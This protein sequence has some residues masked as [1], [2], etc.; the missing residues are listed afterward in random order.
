[1]VLF[2][3]KVPL[4]PNQPR[5]LMMQ[6]QELPNYR[7]TAL[8]FVGVRE[9]HLLVDGCVWGAVPFSRRQLDKGK[10]DV[11]PT[12]RTGKPVFI[13][14]QGIQFFSEQEILVADSFGIWLLTVPRK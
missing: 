1:V 6:V 14:T 13:P 10:V 3:G 9:P 4:R 5:G 7:V 2:D 12:L 8:E 11:F